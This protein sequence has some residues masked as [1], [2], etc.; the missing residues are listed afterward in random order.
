[1]SAYGASWWNRNSTTKFQKDVWDCAEFWI[2]VDSHI[3]YF[4][5]QFVH[6]SSVNDWTEKN[7]MEACQISDNGFNVP[8][9]NIGKIRK[10]DVRLGWLWMFWGRSHWILLTSIQSLDTND[11]KDI[12]SI[13]WDISEVAEQ[14]FHVPNIILSEKSKIGVR[15]R[16][17]LKASTFSKRVL[18]R[19]IWSLDTNERMNIKSTRLEC[20][21]KK[22]MTSTYHQIITE[23]IKNLDVRLPPMSSYSG[24]PMGYYWPPFD[25]WIPMT[26]RI[27]KVS[28]GAVYRHRKQIVRTT[29]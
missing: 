5:C 26:K 25:H 3:G 21:K 1:M 24:G 27:S 15:L 6:W 18:F 17:I 7:Q 12:K 13:Q 9:G 19:S 16:W 14:C 11:Q 10:L 29:R 8:R 22:K 4:W 23:K 20:V 2:I 28:D